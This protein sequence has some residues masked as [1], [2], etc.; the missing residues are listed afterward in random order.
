MPTNDKAKPT[1]KHTPGPLKVVQGPGQSFKI[2]RVPL[3]S[4]PV[5]QWMDWGDAVLYA[6]APEMLA[7]LKAVEAMTGIER[8]YGGE[9]DDLVRA[10]I[11][12]AE[13]R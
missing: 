1:T 9:A 8:E 10:A 11:E 7:A 2:E 13:G 5:A 4:R 12:K 3:G 6:A